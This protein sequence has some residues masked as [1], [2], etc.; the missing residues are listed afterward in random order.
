MT[1]LDD[2]LDRENL[3]NEQRWQELGADGILRKSMEIHTLRQLYNTLK[4][5]KSFYPAERLDIAA[6]YAEPM[7][8]DQIG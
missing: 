2:N 1:I 4:N 3:V 7:Q 5:E 6:R 8:F